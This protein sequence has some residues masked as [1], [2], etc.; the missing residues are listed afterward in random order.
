MVTA[1]PLHGERR[2]LS[3]SAIIKRCPP[4]LATD[5]FDLAQR[6]MEMMKGSRP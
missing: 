6:S 1:R 5:W 4:S 3:W 2:T